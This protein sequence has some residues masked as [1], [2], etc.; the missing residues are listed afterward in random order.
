MIQDSAQPLKG[1][2]L[3]VTVDDLFEW[4][5]TPRIEGYSFEQI[6]GSLTSAFAANGADQVY[7]FSNTAPSD[8]ERTLRSVFD[9]WAEAGHHIGNHTHHHA[10]VDWMSAQ[11]YIDDIERSDALIAP[12]MAR[13][14][15]RYFRHCFDMWGDSAEKQADVGSYLARHGYEIAPISIW[16]YDS[17]FAVAYLRALM[18]G[19]D[20]G[21]AW[22]RARY[23][24]TAVEQ[25]RVQAAAA[26]T[27]FG[28]DPAHIW[29]IHGTAIAADCVDEILAKFQALGVEF[30]T[31]EEAMRDPMN[32]EQPVLTPLFRNQVQ[33]WAMQRNMPIENCPPAI[34]EELDNIT[35]VAGMSGDEIVGSLLGNIAKAL[36]IDPAIAGLSLE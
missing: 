33:K 12:W 34:L 26:R 2:K 23:V 14:P 3:A 7:A 10:S 4:I 28:R 8:D 5:G 19:D 18:A 11:G 6:A 17:Q 15:T 16:F 35:P 13:A 27:I 9:L 21:K 29:L 32:R 24:E 1:I 22:L 31:L 36:D 30:I 25:L 20:D